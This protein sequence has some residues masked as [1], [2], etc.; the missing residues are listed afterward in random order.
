MQI[1]NGR[2]IDTNESPVDHFNFN[3]LQKIRVSLS[4]L[5]GKDINYD[6]INLMS[7]LLRDKG[8]E[9]KLCNVLNNKKILE[10]L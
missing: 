6:K 9:G 1:I 4:T 2:W 10:E 8:N 7:L 3:K 5:Y